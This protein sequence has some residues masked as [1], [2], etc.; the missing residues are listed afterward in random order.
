MT[1]S[2]N[3]T[4][5][6]YFDEWAAEES[7]GQL[8]SLKITLTLMILMKTKWLLQNWQ[9]GLRQLLEVRPGYEHK[10]SPQP[11]LSEADARVVLDLSDDV[12]T[13][14]SHVFA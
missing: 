5:K 3:I 14:K 7:S 9:Q 8:R 12:L 2:F 13:K 6:K 10:D 11:R 4:N 1:Y